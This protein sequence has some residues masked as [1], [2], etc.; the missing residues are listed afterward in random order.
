MTD[1]QRPPTGW[2]VAQKRSYQ[3]KDGKAFGVYLYWSPA[4]MTMQ[5][6][7]DG[8]MDLPEIGLPND[9]AFLRAFAEALEEAAD[10]YE[11]Q[12]AIRPHAR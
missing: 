6:A 5:Q 2:R 4:Y 12:P 1:I 7:P 10:A 8:E 11:R 3:T 9:P